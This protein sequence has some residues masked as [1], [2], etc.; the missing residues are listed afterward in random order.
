MLLKIMGLFMNNITDKLKLCR[1]W[2]WGRRGTAHNT[3]W[4][5]VELVAKKKLEQEIEVSG[6]NNLFAGIVNGAT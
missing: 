2:M 3:E 4:W 5:T 1:R 6:E